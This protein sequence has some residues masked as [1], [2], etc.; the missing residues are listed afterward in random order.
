MKKYAIKCLSNH[1]S[2]PEGHILIVLSK[3][4][5]NVK[6]ISPDI[7]ESGAGTEADPHVM[8]AT[9]ELLGELAKDSEGKYIEPDRKYRDL[10]SDDGNGSI[11]LKQADK[12]SKDRE[13][14]LAGIR[15]HR[16]PLLSEAD[17]EVNKLEDA[18]GDA[19]PMRAY[20]Q[21]LRD[22]TESYKADMSTLDAVS[23]VAAD[24]TWPVKP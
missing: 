15:D 23:D 7:I 11:E 22:V 17:I 14:K 10:L 3:G 20:R 24:V 19:A 13:D 5:P 2:L 21:A 1:P 16:E 12:D 6:A 8:A 4:E 9:A 18:A